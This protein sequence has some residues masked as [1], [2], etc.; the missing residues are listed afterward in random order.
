MIHCHQSN[1]LKTL[2]FNGLET[3]FNK[4]TDEAFIPRQQHVRAYFIGTVI[5]INLSPPLVMESI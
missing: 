1:K 5:F 2:I 4:V 3:T